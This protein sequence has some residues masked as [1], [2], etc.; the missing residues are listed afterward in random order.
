MISF[1]FVL[2]SLLLSHTSK[3]WHINAA[4]TTVQILDATENAFP[5]SLELPT[6]PLSSMGG[7]DSDGRLSKHSTGLRA[8][9]AI[10]HFPRDMTRK[11]FSRSSVGVP[12]VADEFQEIPR[13]DTAVRPV[14]VEDSRPGM[15]RTPPPEMES[16]GTIST[17]EF[18]DEV[19]QWPTFFKFS[20][21]RKGIKIMI[22]LLREWLQID[23]HL[24]F[25][26]SNWPLLIDHEDL[27]V[28]INSQLGG[29]SI[30][31]EF[32]IQE[33]VNIE[34][35]TCLYA[36]LDSWIQPFDRSIHEPDSSAEFLRIIKNAG[37]FEEVAKFALTDNPDYED[38]Y[39]NMDR[40]RA[41]ENHF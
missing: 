7:M 27:V 28:S 13:L 5:S 9:L 29:A 18:H 34:E 8:L 15:P 10:G 16:F 22:L 24:R 6:Q 21:S 12:V 23:E 1:N 17:T 41:L 11:L 26:P 38:L 36:M 2:L 14:R 39:H 35:L 19:K 32:L 40:Q 20:S 30:F 31:R 33:K 37:L 25:D 4:P 3:K